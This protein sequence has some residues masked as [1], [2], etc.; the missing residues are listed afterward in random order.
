M[1]IPSLL[2]GTD[3]ELR[4]LRITVLEKKKLEF[5]FCS[6]TLLCTLFEITYRDVAKE[7]TISGNNHSTG[8]TVDWYS[9][10]EPVSL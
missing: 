5:L 1:V 8:K 3:L 2:A 7:D 6:S 10:Q 4:G 9:L